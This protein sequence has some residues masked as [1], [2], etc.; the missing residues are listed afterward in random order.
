MVG[1]SAVA[2][3]L[4]LYAREPHFEHLQLLAQ[5]P[6]FKSKDAVLTTLL[7]ECL[8][9]Q[10]WNLRRTVCYGDFCLLKSGNLAF[11]GC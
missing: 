8:F 3:W 5:P 6:T 4:H 7:F 1:G 9:H 10:V 11:F 2:S